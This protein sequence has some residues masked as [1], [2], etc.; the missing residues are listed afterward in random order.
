MA[1]AL[2]GFS[3]MNSVSCLPSSP[4]FDLTDSI[5]AVVGR[6]GSGKTTLKSY[7]CE[8]LKASPHNAT[9]IEPEVFEAGDLNTGALQSCIIQATGSDSSQWAIYKD[10]QRKGAESL[11]CLSEKRG[12]SGMVVLIIDESHRLTRATLDALKV[13]NDQAYRGFGKLVHIVLFGQPLLPGKIHDPSN[14]QFE[15]R[16]EFMEI[17]Q[18]ED[19]WKYVQTR[20]QA[21]GSSQAEIDSIFPTDTVS[22]F[23]AKAESLRCTGMLTP[24]YMENIFI[25]AM[26]YSCDAHR[27]KVLPAVVEEI[28]VMEVG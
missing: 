3:R 17:P 23:R 4:A 5:I 19:G 11:K 24:I 12:D 13:L 27:D 7:I 6:P 14:D 28:Q 22:A 10:A 20:L 16:T 2:Y 26:N 21:S 8:I 15:I 9:I 25:K 18:L 1:R